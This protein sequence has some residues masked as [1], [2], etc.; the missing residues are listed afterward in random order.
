MKTPA[1]VTYAYFSIGV[2]S[3]RGHSS[4]AKYIANQI[5]DSQSLLRQ[6]DFYFSVMKRTLPDLIEVKSTY[7]EEGWDGYGA[8][9]LSNESY[10]RAIEFLE[11]LPNSVATPEVDADPDGHVTFEWYK[12][13]YRSLS[14]SVS[15]EGDLHYAALIGPNK[16]NGKEVFN[17]LPPKSILDIMKRVEAP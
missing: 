15:P 3:T 5:C 4:S 1:M 10:D 14:V 17:G 6:S 7:A 2:W 12:S 11:S 8:H 16:A 9:S 13:P